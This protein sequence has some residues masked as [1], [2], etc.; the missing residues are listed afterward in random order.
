MC[1]QTKIWRNSTIRLE[2]SKKDLGPRIILISKMIRSKEAGVLT[3]TIK[4]MS[5]RLILIVRRA[6][7]L[8]ADSKANSRETN[9]IN[10][11]RPTKITTTTI[12][13]LGNPSRT[14]SSRDN[15]RPIRSITSSERK[16]EHSTINPGRQLDKASPML[17]PWQWDSSFSV[18]SWAIWRIELQWR[19]LIWLGK[20]Q[21]EI[22]INKGTV[23]SAAT[24]LRRTTTPC[25]VSIILAAP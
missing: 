4:H 11:R 10:H 5:Q 20:K 1:S 2:T 12:K 24:L 15:S 25:W 19:K 3:I 7:G 23:L 17:Q 8:Q 9:G 18:H 16:R 13:M 14:E 21:M 22:Q 6:K